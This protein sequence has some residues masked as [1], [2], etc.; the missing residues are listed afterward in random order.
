[1]NAPEKP[2]QTDATH[3]KQLGETSPSMAAKI[4]TRIS[5]SKSGLVVTCSLDSGQKLGKYEIR[6]KLGQGGMG[7]V[8]LAY[9]PMIEREVAIKVL[10]PEVSINDDLLK[11][12]LLEARSIGKLNHPNV[13][14]VY[15]IGYEKSICYIVME[16]LTG[17]SLADF[18]LGPEPF[19]WK[20]ACELIAQAADGL[21][22]A[23]AKGLVHR[24]I[25]PEN[26]MQS[27][28]GTVKVVDF[29][30][31]KLLDSTTDSK[32]A[33]TQVGQILGTPHFMSP[34]QFQNVH[35][36]VRS[37]IYSLGVTLFR[38]LTGEFPFQD[39]SSIIQV[40]YAHME[41][42]VP[43]PCQVNPN[44][45]P[46]C[47]NIIDR[48]MAKSREHRYQHA[49][50]MAADLR[51]LVVSGQTTN[52]STRK[53]IDCQRTSA[54]VVE[55]A[56][57]AAM[58]L[59]NSLK[60]AGAESV[61]VCYAANQ[62]IKVV[63]EK[64][65]DLLVTALQ[66]PDCTGID[67]LLKIG[68]DER[69]RETVLVLYSSDYSPRILNDILT[70]GPISVIS[71]SVNQQEFVQALGAYSRLQLKIGGPSPTANVDSVRTLIGC[72]GG[73]VPRELAELIRQI[74]LLD[75][76][77]TTLDSLQESRLPSDIHNYEL[78]FLVP[79]QQHQQSD[80]QRLVELISNLPDSDCTAVAVLPNNGELRMRAIRRRNFA[81]V[82]DVL[83][84]AD[85][86]KRLLQSF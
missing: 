16:L 50:A 14:A 70:Q 85:R 59:R 74:G 40:M 39:C 71:K 27:D 73:R 24:D 83:C 3:K 66:L 65:P 26:L 63:D 41:Q 61:T 15:D 30:L 51:A 43:D 34:E 52:P 20:E 54:V 81:A 28:R 67:L 13:V 72:E 68:Q 33:M 69:F 9:D 37:D 35:V 78:L 10:I 11:R 76:D 21:V 36:D 17:G 80:Q 79:D 8:Y 45:P 48:A 58:M 86:M 84:D 7:S 25:K 31:S 75:V 47:R 53:K 1:M 49:A 22:A 42:P 29:G 23:H 64:I 19:A 5:A 6:R 4:P 55:P 82:T 60:K 2:D 77:I 56:K 46:G 18:K 62:A 32:E 44:L 38:M 57:L 12:F